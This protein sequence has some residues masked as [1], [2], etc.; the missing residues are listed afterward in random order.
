M[1]KPRAYRID[2][3]GGLEA[4]QEE[5]RRDQ[6]GEGGA[7]GVK[8]REYRKRILELRKNFGGLEGGRTVES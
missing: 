3:V 5:N 6:I 2:F 8:G 7:R 4:D 1:E